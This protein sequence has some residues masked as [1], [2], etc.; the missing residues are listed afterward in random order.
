MLELQPGH[1]QYMS[2]SNINKY[3]PTNVFEKNT[4]DGMITA[5]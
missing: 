3:L 4:T 2:D 1:L 5:K